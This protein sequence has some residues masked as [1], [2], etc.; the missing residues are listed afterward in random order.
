M[1]WTLLFLAGILELGFTY[2]LGKFSH[3][4]GASKF[5]WL[6]LLVCSMGASMYII[7]KAIKGI[8]IGTAY[9]VWTGIGAVGTVLMGILFFKEPVS[10]GRLF[11]ISTLIISIIGLKVVSA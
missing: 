9:A 3:A 5:L 1:Y 11:F 8:P 2:S 10:F 7:S 6:I 4:I